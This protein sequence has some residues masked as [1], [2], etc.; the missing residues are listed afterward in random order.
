MT[1]FSPQKQMDHSKFP[2]SF[3]RNLF[4]CRDILE[5]WRNLKGH[6]VLKACF[7]SRKIPP[8]QT[9]RELEL[10][11]S[12]RLISWK[13]VKIWRVKTYITRHCLWFRSYVP[14]LTYTWTKISKIFT[15]EYTFNKKFLSVM[16]TSNQWFWKFNFSLIQICITITKSIYTPVSIKH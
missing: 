10:K 12:R 14:F 2:L 5:I 6:L 9:A 13:Q 11:L 7:R 8:C 16:L 15:T 1:W 4:V 3:V